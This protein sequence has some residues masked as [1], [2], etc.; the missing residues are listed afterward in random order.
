[1]SKAPFYLPSISRFRGATE[2]SKQND[3]L[4]QIFY[5]L[6]ELFNTA[7]LHE[8]EIEQLRK[9]FEVSN[10]YSQ[11]HMDA[12]RREL[13][14]LKEDLYA[15]Q[16]PG[17]SYIKTLLA[18]DA[19]ADRLS[20]EHEKALVDTQHGIITLPYSSYSSSKLYLY[21]S[22]N[23]EYILPNTIK[24]DITPVSDGKTIREND[25]KDAL[26]PDE[27]RLWHREYRYFSGLK[28]H[29]E[30]QIVLTLPDNIIS[31]RDV[32]TLYVHPF[33]LNSMD[34]V[35]IEYQ[36]DGGWRKLP[37]FKPVEDA[38]NTKFCFSP[39]EMSKVRITLRQ[40]HFIEK[41]GQQVF[42]MG[43]RELGIAHNDY[44]TGIGRFEM[45][46]E[47]NPAFTNKEVV[48]VTPYYQNEETLSVHQ[49]NSR[50]LTF[51]VYEVDANGKETYISDAFPIQIKETKILLKGIL[52]FDRN[53]RSTP[54][55]SRVE[56]TY[57]GDS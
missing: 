14:S 15:V 22:L 16:R 29:A 27:Y 28:E 3:H 6:T 34:I 13:D 17:E 50:L 43:I 25:F 18:D 19:R 31:N 44:Q 48:S 5:D 52:S 24:Y 30:A 45:P 42:H 9:F 35:N 7:N 38:S 32:N 1:M 39:I 40:R 26:T 23:E 4:E 54:A 37:G 12:M 47:F 8:D 33:P 56:V 49:K 10:H 21:D 36:L 53:T 55:L 41:G 2:S 20:E 11:E 57:K 46:L 51:S